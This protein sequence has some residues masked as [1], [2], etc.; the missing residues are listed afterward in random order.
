MSTLLPQLRTLLHPRH[1]GISAAV[2]MALSEAAELRA[3]H[4]DQKWLE[5]ILPKGEH[6]KCFTLPDMLDDV[7]GPM[8]NREVV[9]RGPKRRRGRGERLLVHEIRLP[10]E[11]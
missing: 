9:V 4:L 6:E 1:P 7:A 2:C 10:D 3:L 8:V 11:D 5:L